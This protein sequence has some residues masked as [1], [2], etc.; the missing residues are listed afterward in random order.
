MKAGAGDRI[1]I[2]GRHL[3]DPDRDGEIVAVEGPDGAP[4]Y[5][6]RWEADGHISLF[7]PGPDVTIQH[8]QPRTR[9]AAHVA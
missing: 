1:I 9:P 6:V 3:G 5:W 2:K 7:F 4:P 8:Y